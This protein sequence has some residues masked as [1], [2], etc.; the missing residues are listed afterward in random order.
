MVESSEGMEVELQGGQ[1]GELAE[2]R[3]KVSSELTEAEKIQKARQEGKRSILVGDRFKMIKTYEFTV[4]VRPDLPEKHES[5]LISKLEELIKNHVGDIVKKEIW[6]VKPLQYRIRKYD[7][8]KFYY[9]EYESIGIGEK[10]LR[11]FVDTS[12]DFLR[13]LIV[14]KENILTKGHIW[15]KK[16]KEQLLR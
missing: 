10:I 2:E 12:S 13:Y 1:K 8:A 4:A 11:A 16:V 3:D 14:K 15:R 7:R 5:E 9:F 6:G